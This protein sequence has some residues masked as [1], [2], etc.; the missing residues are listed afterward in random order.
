MGLITLI[1]ALLS[2][3]KAES[4]IKIYKMMKSGG[5]SCNCTG[6][7]Y[8]GKVLSMGLRKLGKNKVP[9]ETDSGLRGCR[10][11]FGKDGGLASIAL[12]L[13]DENGLASISDYTFSSSSKRHHNQQRPHHHHGVLREDVIF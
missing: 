6:N 5:W 7:D 9:D 8:V 3:D 2:A 4:T 12:F 1:K 11:H 13:K 10:W